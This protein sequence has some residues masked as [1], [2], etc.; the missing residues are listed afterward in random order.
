MFADTTKRFSLYV[1]R[2][3][4][5]DIHT[6]NISGSSKLNFIFLRKCLCRFKEIFFWKKITL[7]YEPLRQD[8]A[9]QTAP[10]RPVRPDSVNKTAPYRP[11]R[12]DSV[13]KTVPYRPVRPDSVNKIAAYRPVRPDSVKKIAPYR[14]G[15]MA[16]IGEVIQIQQKINYSDLNSNH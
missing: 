3:R 15:K 10:Y 16:F 4:T 5:H 8:S 1:E 2:N 7:S 13:N 12:T 6:K 11:V 9:N 14:S